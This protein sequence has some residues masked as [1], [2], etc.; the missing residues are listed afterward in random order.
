MATSQ[1]A[2]DEILRYNSDISEYFNARGLDKIEALAEFE[3]IRKCLGRKIP[4]RI[5]DITLTPVAAGGFPLAFSFLLMMGGMPKEDAMSVGVPFAVIFAAVGLFS[6]V[7]RLDKMN[8]IDF[9]V[10]ELKQRSLVHR[11]AQS[12]T[13]CL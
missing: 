6:A 12:Q 9:T 7:S 13:A 4:K 11:H 3:E 8:K 1:K 5:A 2:F 10:D